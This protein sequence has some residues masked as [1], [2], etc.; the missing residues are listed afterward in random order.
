MP[1]LVLGTGYPLLTSW[2]LRALVRWVG[3]SS[4]LQIG[5]PRLREMKVLIEVP[6]PRFSTR[7]SVLLYLVNWLASGHMITS[8]KVGILIYGLTLFCVFLY[9][10][11]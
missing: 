6:N 8:G 2:V 9:H 5:K 3:R 1:D 11:V 4:I 10:V 7:L